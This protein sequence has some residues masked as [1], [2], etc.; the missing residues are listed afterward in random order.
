VRMQRNKH[1]GRRVKRR[2]LEN[3]SVVEIGDIGKRRFNKMM[4]AVR[5]T[6]TSQLFRVIV[7]HRLLTH[8]GA[9]GA[10]FVAPQMFKYVQEFKFIQDHFKGHGK[11]W[12]IFGWLVSYFFS[13]R[14]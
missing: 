9:F 1:D 14:S 8:Y 5:D 4:T 6:H 7:S 10:K 12:K 13:C 11:R 3:Y 2:P